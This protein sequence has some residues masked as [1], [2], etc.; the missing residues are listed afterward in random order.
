MDFWRFHPVSN[1]SYFLVEGHFNFL[2]VGLSVL[3]AGFA[4]YAALVVLVQVWGVKVHKN[5]QLW[6]FFGS[7]VL[8]TGIWAMHFT[9]MLAFVMP[10]PMSYDPFLTFLSVFP[11]II[12]AYFTLRRLSYKHFT[13]INIQLAALSL[14]LGI[15]FMHFIG[16]EA[17]VLT[18]L[19]VYDLNLFITSL[20]FAHIQSSIAIALI[21][22]VHKNA[23]NRLSARLICAA[24]IGSAISG[25]HYTAM[26]SVSFYFDQAVSPVTPQ[27][28]TQSLVLSLVITGI[29]AIFVATTVLMA[30]I[31]KKLFLAEETAKASEIREKDILE[32]LAD[33][34]FVINDKGQIHQYNSAAL[35]MFE[36]QARTLDDCTLDKL[37]PAISEQQLMPAILDKQSNIIG[38]TLALEGIKANGESFP[39][40]VTFSKMTLMID[41]K[42]MFNCVVRDI[43]TRVRL[44]NKLHHAM[45]LESVG[46][47]ASGIAHE[48]NTPTQYVVDNTSFLQAAFANMLPAIQG[49]RDF[50]ENRDI[51]GAE[52]VKDLL[53]KADFE[54]LSA[55]V[56]LAISQSLEG[57]TRISAIV[58]AMKSF[59]HP[60]RGRM[61]LTNITEAITTTLTVARSEWRNVAEV[62]TNFDDSL[63]DIMCIRD[64]FNQVILNI[65][66][67]AAHAIAERLAKD[68]DDEKGKIIINTYRDDIDAIITI[69][70]NGTGMTEKTLSR[71]FDPFYTT[72]GVG[73]GTGQ[74]LSMAYKMIVEQH[75]GQLYAESVYGEGSIFTIQ[76][77]VKVQRAAPEQAARQAAEV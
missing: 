5:K 1:P 62:E 68:K 57:L 45:K 73:K 65:I 6:L 58:G 51:D 33:G 8:G 63:P 72:K 55:E 76:L 43:S 21:T 20:V 2:L 61:Q 56:P 35:A 32:Q 34:W 53:D 7:F 24:V 18:G 52:K 28:S 9:G 54:F 17:M 37:M 15:S 60:S 67:N 22:I 47:L 59:S 36:Y 12:G 71:I 64:E 39:I 10:M 46:Q 74:G 4:A 19:M 16:M 30:L 38:Q 66:V 14:S 44:E 70:D 75:Q 42:I 49:C 27:M 26:A 41:F 23:Q 11:A 31:D 3:V 50:F 48:I 29:V 77:P 69:E 13:L 25:M 40:E